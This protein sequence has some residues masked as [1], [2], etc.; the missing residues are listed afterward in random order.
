MIE[1]LPRILFRLL[2]V[3]PNLILL[4]FASQQPNSAMIFDCI[5]LTKEHLFF[6]CFHFQSE[7]WSQW[8]YD[9]TDEYF[10]KYLQFSGIE[11]VISTDWTE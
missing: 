1:R 6:Y 7:S 11:P 9:M 5:I 4:L 3:G 2:L 10:S 8:P